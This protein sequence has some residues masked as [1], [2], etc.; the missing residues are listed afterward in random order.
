MIRLRLYFAD[1]C[2]TF[3]GDLSECALQIR[4]AQLFEGFKGYE[5]I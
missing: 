5:I 3:A 1:R 2:L 4:N